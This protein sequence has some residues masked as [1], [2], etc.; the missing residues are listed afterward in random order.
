[1]KHSEMNSSGEIMTWE[2][3]VIAL[4]D[5]SF[6]LGDF[7]FWHQGACPGQC[8]SAGCLRCFY[9]ESFGLLK[10]G[11]SAARTA[12]PAG[13]WNESPLSSPPV[14]VRV[15]T[16]SYGKLRTFLPV[17][18]SLRKQNCRDYFGFYLSLPPCCL[19]SSGLILI[20]FSTDCF[21]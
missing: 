21:S 7:A 6:W 13:Y 10:H 3:N 2:A 20:M 18:L 17:Q 15:V 4:L 9:G 12:I 11:S 5:G 16:R 19:E 14:D 8:F 1:M